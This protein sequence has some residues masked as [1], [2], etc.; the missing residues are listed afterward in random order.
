MFTASDLWMWMSLVFAIFRSVLLFVPYRKYMPNEKWRVWWEI[1]WR[2]HCI[3]RRSRIV[4]IEGIDYCEYH[5]T[6]TLSQV[7]RAS[8]PIITKIVFQESLYIQHWRQNIC[9]WK[10]VFFL[11][12]NYSSIEHDAKW[13][14]KN[15]KNFI[16]FIIIIIK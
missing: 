10:W 6:D 12:N 1:L 4:E 3:W 14:M 2:W 15:E 9:K 13:K 11:I 7:L 16:S 8:R 5:Y